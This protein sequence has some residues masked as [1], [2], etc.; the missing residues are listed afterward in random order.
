MP[1]PNNIKAYNKLVAAAKK[2][3][4]PDPHLTASIAML[5]SGWMTSSFA[6]QNNPFGQTIYDS[7]I[8]KKGI[9]SGR[10]AADGLLTAQYDSLDS[11]MKHHMDKWGEYYVG[12]DPKEILNNL[13][14]G[15]YNTVNPKWADKI[16]S[17]HTGP[18]TTKARGLSIPAQKFPNLLPE[19][20]VKERHPDRDIQ[21]LEYFDVMDNLAYTTSLN[22]FNYF[23]QGGVHNINKM[24][25]KYYDAGG[26]DNAPVLSV[27]NNNP[28]NLRYSENLTKPGYVLEKATKGDA[29]FAKFNTI[30]EGIEAMKKQLRL[31]LVKREMTLEEF[32]NK[33]APPTE[34][35]TDVYI[36][37]I[38]KAIDIDPED[39]VSSDKID[40]L[41]AAMII[42]E[43]GSEAIDYYKNALPETSV[44]NALSSF[45]IDNTLDN[46]AQALGLPT[47][48]DLN[49]ELFGGF[50]SAEAQ[51]AAEA[52]YYANTNQQDII[53]AIDA[54][55]QNP[56]DFQT[57]GTPEDE[58]RWY[59]ENT[60]Q[61]GIINQIANDFAA[62]QAANQ[63]DTP[64]EPTAED[65]ARLGIN[66][67]A[68]ARQ[69]ADDYDASQIVPSE[70]TSPDFGGF[71]SAEEQ[72]AAEKAWYDKRN[73]E[74]ILRQLADDYES[75]ADSPMRKPNMLEEDAIA[76]DAAIQ[77]ERDDYT[78]MTQEEID[79]TIRDRALDEFIKKEVSPYQPPA[80]RMAQP[81]GNFYNRDIDY[82][83]YT[84]APED[85]ED[86]KNNAVNRN[87]LAKLKGQ[88]Y[89][90]LLSDIGAYAAR[91][92]PLQ[93]ALRDASSYDEERYPR[94]SPII[95]TATL[96]K[97]DVRDAFATAQQ[98]AMQQGRLDL[99]ALS[100][101]AT[102]QAKETARVE[103]NVANERVGLLNQAQ[104]LNNQITMQ[105]MADTAANK[106]AAA[107]MKYQA[108]AAMSQ[109]GQG[110]LR[111][112]NMR[113][114]DQIVK[115]MFSNVFGDE[116]G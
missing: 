80:T 66:S 90:G 70:R 36:N 86:T 29:G 19:V 7:Q 57:Q 75:D 52:A 84:T 17:I 8:G 43:G 60:N 73:Q 42:Q 85:T 115:N 74:G 47:S 68:I 76:R 81:S 1:D 100:A 98:A 78:P 114:N 112:A 113:R 111:E 97:R 107:T 15:G 96:P 59:A 50:E 69:I 39:K 65:Y 91:M 106:G 55:T 53:N 102:Q 45:N 28:G 87:L 33:Y 4:S 5:E 72:A 12:N 105:E 82:K 108:L 38:A 71:D 116:F 26:V 64:Y 61:E 11:A 18:T 51:A 48:Q 35:K 46:T 34:N 77:A 63:L 79:A 92:A 3:G 103:E 6:K 99:G 94:F 30:E 62:S 54:V 9:V 95:P 22:D 49:D 21:D 32:L 41:A 104:Q 27:R 101:L 93:R 40:D 16:Y 37:N 44:R 58:A 14:R 110:S 109:M 31:D 24:N 83:K 67:N 88:D 20:I 25:K 23:A 2:A 10:P 56:E 89:M 13:V